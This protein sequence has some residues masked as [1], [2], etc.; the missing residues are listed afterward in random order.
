MELKDAVAILGSRTQ[1]SA[2]G[3]YAVK[4]TNCGDFHKQL[5]RGSIVAI[6]NFNAMNGYQVGKAKELIQA[7]DFSGAL[8]QN[9]SLSIRDKD[10]RPAKGEMVHIIV[11]EVETKTGEKALLATSLTP[12][13][14]TT[15]SKVDFSAM[16]EEAPAQEAGDEA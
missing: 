7:G 6:A 8:N 1:I 3:K 5:E 15:G 13:A 12:I 16:L 14:A 10:Y 9:L 4:V 11:E 2:P